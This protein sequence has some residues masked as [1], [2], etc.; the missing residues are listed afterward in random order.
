MPSHRVKNPG[1]YQYA[2]DAHNLV[3]VGRRSLANRT[4]F[5]GGAVE[6]V[7]VVMIE[8]FAKKDIGNEF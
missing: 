1:T 8:I 4:W 6:N 7:E 3:K 2:A 5:A